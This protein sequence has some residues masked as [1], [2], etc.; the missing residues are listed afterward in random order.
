MRPLVHR[1]DALLLALLFPLLSSLT[2]SALGSI[3]ASGTLVNVTIDDTYGDELFGTQFLYAPADVWNVGQ[4]CAACTAHPNPALVHNG[5][6]HDGTTQAGSDQLTTATVRFEGAFVSRP[7]PCLKLD[8]LVGVA[9]YV[10][11]IVTRSSTSPDGNSDMTFSIDGQEVGRFVQPPDG[12][13]TYDYNVPVYVN[14]SLPPGP[15]QLVILN[16]QPNGNKS[17]ILLDYVVY[18]CVVAS[19]SPAEPTANY[20]ACSQ[21]VGTTP[22]SPSDTA[23]QSSPPASSSASVSITMTPTSFAATTGTSSS[24]NTTQKRTIIIAVVTVCGVLGLAAAIV[25]ISYFCLRKRYR[26]YD[27]PPDRAVVPRSPS[28][29]EVNPATSGWAEGTW[30]VEGEDQPHPSLSTSPGARRVPVLPGSPR[31]SSSRRKRGP[32]DAGAT[33]PPDPSA[34][35]PPAKSPIKPPTILHSIPAFRISPSQLSHSRNDPPGSPASSSWG[36][37]AHMAPPDSATFL[38]PPLPTTSST[39]HVNLDRTYVETGGSTSTLSSHNVHPFAKA[40]A[41]QVTQAPLARSRSDKSNAPP[42]AMPPSSY[43]TRPRGNSG[44]RALPPVPDTLSS[45][46]TTP[47]TPLSAPYTTNTIDTDESFLPS[48]SPADPSPISLAL[49]RIPVPHKQQ[50][51]PLRQTPSQQRRR[52]VDP[53]DPSMQPSRDFRPTASSEQG[54]DDERTRLAGGGTA[55]N[56]GPADG[57]STGPSPGQRDRRRYG[58]LDVPTDAGDNRPGSYPDGG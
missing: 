14:T 21:D 24:P 11:C 22:I 15:H 47:S 54:H 17:L 50:Q 7:R 58:F 37:P 6:W 19:T 34:P 26:S 5:T 43:A 53:V 2:A 40:R 29:I 57:R 45:G 55:G 31:K 27:A 8:L 41:V 39:S 18:T 3:V 25:T 23:S 32:S 42:S 35:L 38:I 48:P 44:S 16:G 28:H 33:P 49:N 20:A 30:A 9:V 51:H 1:L 10:F 52:R 46:T 13:T 4:S 56:T 36:T 12:D